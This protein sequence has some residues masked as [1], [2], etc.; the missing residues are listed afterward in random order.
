[1]LNSQGS[2][3]KA[4]T[5]VYALIF[6]TFIFLCYQLMTSS[7]FPINE[8]GIKGEYENVN[9]SQVDLIKNK[10]IKKNF[11]AV[12]LEETR[13]AF[14]KLPWI[15]DVSIRR[16]WNKFG[17]LVEI[18]S[19]K[20]IARWSSRGLVNSY[21]EIF[22]AAYEDNLPLFV[23]PD[24]FVEE[25]SVK[26]YQIN[27]ILEKEL[28][29]IGT[30]SLSNRLSWEIYTNN[31]M[32]FFLGKENGNNIVKKLNALIENYQFIL[33]ESKSRIEYVDLRYKD[34][35]AVK[36]LNEKLYKTNKEKKTT[37]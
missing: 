30:I 20:P 10:Y 36:K 24:E 25:M 23:G 26:Y 28:M 22:H 37:L 13:E 14:K 5:F 34:G 32:R 1:M 18:E 16:D 4:T 7:N 15:R 19:H 3:K 9:K 6:I 8:I 33:S 35:F 2:I 27:K 21:G 17:L 31:N 12:N 29:Q 11:F